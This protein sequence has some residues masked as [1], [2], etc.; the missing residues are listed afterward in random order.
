TDARTREQVRQVYVP[1]PLVPRRSYSVMT[2][3]RFASALPSMLARAQPSA[4]V[5]AL[6][7]L[8]DLYRTEARVQLFASR[9]VG[10]VGVLGLVLAL[11]GLFAVAG[12][13]TEARRRE[14]GIRQAVGASRSGIAL[15]SIE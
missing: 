7:S 1:F 8:R 12:H 11:V 4:S 14:F 5:S 2:D 9:A 3:A 6:I 15:L 13:A 10:G